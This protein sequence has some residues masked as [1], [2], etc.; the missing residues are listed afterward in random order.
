MD[1]EAK[2]YIDQCSGDFG[3]FASFVSHMKL[4]ALERGVDLLLIDSGLLYFLF[5]VPFS[6]TAHFGNR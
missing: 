4:Q 1:Y 5:L 2:K 3:D 6:L